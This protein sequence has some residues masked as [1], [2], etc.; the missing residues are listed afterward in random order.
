VLLLEVTA[1][2]PGRGSAGGNGLGGRGEGVAAL[3][4]ENAPTGF[5]GAWR[6]PSELGLDRSVVKPRQP[7]KPRQQR[8]S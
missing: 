7:K 3:L 1:R 5:P 2:N 8:S 4:L 6:G